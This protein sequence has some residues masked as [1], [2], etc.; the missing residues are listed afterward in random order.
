M[1]AHSK[2]AGQLRRR[3][4]SFSPPGGTQALCIHPELHCTFLGGVRVLGCPLA[5][6][7]L[8]TFTEGKEGNHHTHNP[9]PGPGLPVSFLATKAKGKIRK[10]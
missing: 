2:G 3:I 4:E 5:A 10:R 1:D 8:K 9:P 6:R 7:T